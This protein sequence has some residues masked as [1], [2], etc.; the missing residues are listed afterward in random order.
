MILWKIFLFQRK[1]IRDT[2][3]ETTRK[4]KDFW[5]TFYS[6]KTEKWENGINSAEWQLLRREDRLSYSEE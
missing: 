4:V 3:V 5:A 2:G 1:Y 6:W